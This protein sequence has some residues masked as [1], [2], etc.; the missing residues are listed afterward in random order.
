MIIEIVLVVVLIVLVAAGAVAIIRV[1]RSRSARDD[2]LGELDDIRRSALNFDD[3]DPLLGESR[4]LEGELEGED[5]D[6]HEPADSLEGNGS[7]PPP[8][9]PVDAGPDEGL[10]VPDLPSP[11]AAAKWALGSADEETGLEESRTEPDTVADGEPELVTDGEPDT[12]AEGALPT[13]DESEPA[14]PESESES[15][16]G[17][18]SDDR[19]ESHLP[20]G[21]VSPAPPP[22]APVSP[23]VA[24][25]GLQPDV[26][27][28]LGERR[29][30]EFQHGDVAI[31]RVE[32]GSATVARRETA[33]GGTILAIELQE[34][35]V[36]H[37]PAPDAASQITLTVH[38]PAGWVSA[39]G[40]NVLITSEPDG[41]CY[42]MCLEGA[43]TVETASQRATTRLEAGQVGRCR[44][45]LAEL[46]V[47]AA[48]PEAIEGDELIQLHLGFDAA[49]WAA[50]A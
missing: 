20:P 9:V 43:C 38:T 22:G 44:V 28:Q 11:P 23:P 45:D 14:S 24:L 40:A 6:L 30:E 36:W 15:E 32:L 10:A 8:S 21:A 34:G 26:V 2:W 46:Q 3:D 17:P 4:K 35:S 37:H 19:T 1:T 49:R 31:T 5:S 48:Q 27:H 29:F 42:T 12:T 16:A 33:F 50:G 39:H 7:P 47:A 18:E 25:L 41:W 13:E